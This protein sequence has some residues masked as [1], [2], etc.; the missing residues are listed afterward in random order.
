MSYTTGK[1]ARIIEYLSDNADRSYTIEEICAVL[2]EDG[3]GRSTVY[4]LVSELVGEGSLA[5]LSDG[6]TRH[7]TYQYV[8]GELC[9]THL[10]LKCKGCGRLVHLD[11]AISEEFERTVSRIGGFSIDN[12]ALLLGVCND[13]K[14]VQA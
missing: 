10:H 9:H 11:R 5:R 6:R 1:R 8:G 13:C 14:E 3:K 4:R 2:T 7:C 12:G